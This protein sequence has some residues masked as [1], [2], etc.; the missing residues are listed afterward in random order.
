MALLSAEDERF[1]SPGPEKQWS[2]SLYFGGADPR[3]LALYTRIGRR[4]N[5]DRIEAALGVWLPDG[6][7]LLSFAREED[8]DEP[9]AG[10]LRYDC[11]LP[12]ELWRIWVDGRGRLFERAEDLATK[13]AGKDVAVGGELRF[14]TWTRP[15]EFSTG[16]T[17]SVAARHYEQPGSLAGV[18]TIDGERH[19]VAGRGLRDHSWGVRDWQRV[20]YWRWMGMV[21]DPDTFL[22]LNAVG[23]EDGGETVGGHLMLGGEVAPIVACDTDSETG[24][25]GFQRR[26]TARARDEL[27]REATLEGEA[28]SVAP[29]RQ[30]RDGR[31]THV[32]EA[33]TRLRWEEHEGLGIS[34]YLVQSNDTGSRS[35]P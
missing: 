9:E 12:Y 15:I 11:A 27:G 5:E 24:P 13:G 35:T 31:L 7:F 3:G 34:E 23:R 22:L 20:P 26:F 28:V 29:L 10:A 25:G 32:F 18:L 21:V 6:R 19:P 8:H 16:L 30:R 33:L 4:P 17:D 2:D 14:A 1:H